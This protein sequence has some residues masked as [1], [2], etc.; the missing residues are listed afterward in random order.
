M[1]DMLSQK[2]NVVKGIDKKHSIL[3]INA[4]SA[5][6]GK[7]F[8]A[9][10]MELND[11][12]EN[13]IWKK[14]GWFRGID[15]QWKFE[16]YDGDFDLNM[17]IIRQ[18]RR[19]FGR[20]KKQTL[21]TTLGDILVGADE[22]FANY[23]QLKNVPVSFARLGDGIEGRVTNEDGALLSAKYLNKVTRSFNTQYE[24]LSTVMHE[25][26]H[27]IQNIENFAA[28]T[29]EEAWMDQQDTWRDF[30][31][32]EVFNPRALAEQELQQYSERDPEMFDMVT[33]L[34]DLRD[35]ARN[36]D[37]DT[38]VY[39]R[40][41]EKVT[42]RYVPYDVANILYNLDTLQLL[43]DS[44][45][46]PDWLNTNAEELYDNTAGEIEARDVEDRLGLTERERRARRPNTPIETS[47]FSEEPYTSYGKN[48]YSVL[49]DNLG[50]S[51]NEPNGGI[52][53]DTRRSSEED[54][55][56]TSGLYGN[57]DTNAEGR[58][59]LGGL[60]ETSGSVRLSDQS[61][62]AIKD[63]SVAYVE[64]NPTTDNAAF[65]MRLDEARDA[66]PDHGWA[67]SPKPVDE[68]VK[69]NLRLFMSADGSTGFALAPDGDIEAVFRNQLTG[70]RK[71][72][73]SS[74]P[75]AIANGGTKLDCYGTGLLNFYTQYGFI[76]V[77]RVEF[78]PKYANPGWTPEKGYPEIIFMMHNGDSAEDVIRNYG[79]YRAYTA[80]EIAALPLY[81]KEGYD[82][83]YAYRDGELAKLQEEQKK[84]S[85]LDALLANDEE[86]EDLL[87]D[88]DLLLDGLNLEESGE[89]S[90]IEEEEES[91]PPL[92]E[93]RPSRRVE[94]GTY[95]PTAFLKQKT[96]NAWLSGSGFASPGSKNY[97][98]AYIGWMNPDDFLYLT[99]SSYDVEDLKRAEGYYGDV[100][101]ISQRAQTAREADVIHLSI[102]HE[103]G[104]V[105]GHEG[106][107][108]MDMLQ[109]LG[110]ENV[111]VLFFDS[112]NK[113]DKEVMP[114][115]TLIGEWNKNRRVTLDNDLIPL[116]ENHRSEIEA[117]FVNR[118]G[119]DPN[120]PTVRFSLLSEPGETYD[121]FGDEVTLPS[122]ELDNLTRSDL[123]D[124]LYYSSDGNTAYYQTPDGQVIV[125]DNIGPD[126]PEAQYINYLE[127]M[128]NANNADT[129]TTKPYPIPPRSR[130]EANGYNLGEPDAG[131]RRG[132]E[133]VPTQNQ[134][135]TLRRGGSPSELYA[136]GRPQ[137]EEA[138]SLR[139]SILVGPSGESN[140]GDETFPIVNERGETIT[141]A[142]V[143]PLESFE[144]HLLTALRDNRTSDMEDIINEWFDRGGRIND[145][146][147]TVLADEIK[148]NQNYSDDERK[149]LYA[150]IEKARKAYGD[151]AKGRD[152][153]KP[154]VI[155]PKKADNGDGTTRNIRK[156]I[157][158]TAANVDNEFLT[159]ALMFKAMND[160]MMGY[161]PQS[162]PETVQKARD[163]I[164][165]QFHGSLDAAYDY[166]RAM[167]ESGKLPSA[168]EIAL[169]EI[170]IKEFGD[171]DR[172]PDS[173]N[174]AI[175]VAADLAILGTDLGQAIQA[176]R[177]IKKATPQGQLYYLDGVVKHLNAQYAQR[178]KDGKMKP[179]EIKEALAA[180]LLSASTRQE[181]NDAIE[182]IK[183]D[184]AN[185]I[186]VTLWDQWNAWRYLAM[187]GNPRTHIRNIFGNAFFMPIVF[188]KDMALRRL[189]NSNSLS[190]RLLSAT[191]GGDI[192]GDEYKTMVSG[193]D[194]S[195]WLFKNNSNPYV[196]FAREDYQLMQDIV[197]GKK[198]GSKYSDANDIISRRKIFENGP[199]KSRFLQKYND[200]NS[201]WLEREDT[202]FQEKYYIRY[203]A[204]YLQAQ[205]ITEDQLTGD[206]MF[207]TTPEGRKIL[208]KARQYAT[209]QAQ[210]DTYHE[211][212]QFAMELN[213]MKGKGGWRYVLG[214]GLVPF[215]GTPANLLKLA[216]VQ[217]SPYG[218]MRSIVDLKRAIREGNQDT[219]AILDNLASGLTGT[220][221]ILLGAVLAAG[222][223][224][225]KLRGAG[226]DDDKEAEFE[227]MQGHQS[228]AI[229]TD[230]WSYTID[231]MAPLCMPLFVGATM[232]ELFNRELDLSKPSAFSTLL[233]GIANPM[234]SMSMLDGIENT[235]SSLRYGGKNAMATLA[236][237]MLTSYF[238]QGVP[239]IAGQAARTL[240]DRRRAT[241][242][243]PNSK[244]P[245]AI[246]QFW[247][248][249]IQN[250]I[251]D[252]GLLFGQ[253][254][255]P[256]EENKAE[257]VDMWGRN[258]S[259]GDT[260]LERAFWNFLSPGYYREI[261][262][263]AVDAEL[264]RLYEAIGGTEGKKA[265]PT[266]VGK[267][268]SKQSQGKDDEGNPI[269]L[270]GKQL[271]A[272]E[273]VERQKVKGQTAYAILADMFND[274]LYQNATDNEK[275][276]MVMD[277]Y[278]LAESL[279]D[280]SII[281][282]RQLGSSWMDTAMKFGPSDYIL[283]KQDYDENKSNDKIYEWIL[284]TPDLTTDQMAI[285]FADKFNIPDYIDSDATGYRYKILNADEEP[286][287]ALNEV[288]L[289]QRL[290]ELFND[291]NFI[292]A[293]L[294]EQASR[295]KEFISDVRDETL[296][297]YSNMLSSANREY[298]LGKSSRLSGSEKFEVMLD[299]KDGDHK[300]QADWIAD[301]YRGDKVIDNPD[302]PGYEFELA[303]HERG[304]SSWMYK[305]VHT[306][307]EE[308][309]EELWSGNSKKAK[310]F[311]DAAKRNDK[312]TMASIAEDVYK[313][314]VQE[315]ERDYGRM[316]NSSGTATERFKE[317][318]TGYT[319]GEA[320]KIAAEKYGNDYDAIGRYI[321][322]TIDNHAV[323][324]DPE[325]PGFFI[326]L[327]SA[328]QDQGKKDREEM[329]TKLFA[330]EA[331]KDY[332]KT[333]TD[334][335]KGEYIKGFIHA[336]DVEYQKQ[337]AKKIK[338]AGYDE[339]TIK[340]NKPST[341]VDE[342]LT[343]MANNNY[344]KEETVEI[345][346]ARYKTDHDLQDVNYNPAGRILQINAARAYYEQH[347]D[348]VKS[349]AMTWKQYRDNASKAANAA[350]TGSFGVKSVG[351]IP[352]PGY[353][354]PTINPSF[355][356]N[357]SSITVPSNFWP[358]LIRR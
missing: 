140:R 170:L 210:R 213:R 67:V 326:V 39:E 28:G 198:S 356:S 304:E 119:E 332:F 195:G 307:Y 66:D 354:V 96:L 84:Y 336:V 249:S 338:D 348:D 355:E 41:L 156:N 45:Y 59:G 251:P 200:F 178:I 215:T 308:A 324:E 85:Y 238:A 193:A 25:V 141:T 333:A 239:T 10:D 159:E 132:A 209:L 42:K 342:F 172:H 208:N 329:F 204:E 64:I 32:R 100:D 116:N 301:S 70:T 246:Q 174:K 134:E 237:S 244:W 282:E 138:Q 95:N 220:G 280:K 117:E 137:S 176:L 63:R 107:H 179:V 253:D 75:L 285:L 101:N 187:L 29:S 128:N 190:N 122:Y 123:S 328:Q 211:M 353:E 87:N 186:P 343:H 256:S 12:T 330:S 103:T 121:A 86:F 11:A 112:S 38:A 344:S 252:F 110:V 142:D 148:E 192:I 173:M 258:Q 76:P 310:A 44:E 316:L 180:K 136:E 257:Y 352:D 270:D 40:Q 261:N 229:E 165:N 62:Q 88:F 135:G 125:L 104:K 221:L 318:P 300:A 162:N 203:L 201:E 340:L 16:L 287:D 232:Y 118:E 281:P 292:N 311:Q 247:Q 337:Y 283:I 133:E 191:M 27:L 36:G 124:N 197:K 206:N 113:Y 214:E 260:L 262:E 150:A 164:K 72:T 18:M 183:E 298:T 89:T 33:K 155:L 161:T 309:Y 21:S 275:L 90:E 175:N 99:T 131:L 347:Y 334:E 226:P 26:Q 61:I 297:T 335:E 240:D 242:I 111:P 216:A 105:Y 7:L 321:A 284:T 266:S 323:I 19:D 279:A 224:G 315:V 245:G 92:E 160:E 34:A 331:K 255:Y 130:Y 6:Y 23:P 199:I 82:D 194:L 227:E 320:Y 37:I 299:A 154:N 313:A 52:T 54:T 71:S 312:V 152:D 158:T 163:M 49:E 305:E 289:Q 22:L 79:T 217:Y 126:S 185:Q 349:G 345:M 31:E 73:M 91:L 278:S 81:G 114:N 350:A 47:I 77:A 147:W 196:K 57:L 274:E 351:K 269:T 129:T 169:G 78:N 58:G 181:L 184:L 341:N 259:T 339:L 267:E 69:Y 306:R 55:G 98:Q 222:G 144:R 35:Q 317:K 149:A 15:G 303:D 230:G 263:T 5:D 295:L 265:L 277:A 115:P 20:N 127:A 102:D 250:K 290:P 218:L 223:L 228:W 93:R 302:H 4:K 177:I 171:G 254:W 319:S 225:F 151:L 30:V 153:K 106:R 51:Y 288:L 80:E 56:R 358:N 109:R 68:I 327:N 233:F 207:S 83:A 9:I 291:E 205:G 168:A 2:F 294:D 212:N 94:H 188:V 357:T 182:E 264:D 271:T 286:L 65:S 325:N 13:D 74:L 235:L 273:Y 17:D 14:T 231:W 46:Y 53:N 296:Q 157:Q 97:A 276:K 166:F 236:A 314:T 139:H 167:K 1:F 50:E 120:K 346:M 272:D 219:A 3:G 43:E 243:D 322:K 248:S 268:I 202:G 146:S 241:Y 24:L 8:E 108:R 189:Q 60:S 145:D 234:L 293:G 48:R 143:Y